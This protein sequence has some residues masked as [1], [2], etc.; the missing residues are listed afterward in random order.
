MQCSVEKEHLFDNEYMGKDYKGGKGRQ[1]PSMCGSSSGS[2]GKS[3]DSYLTGKDYPGDCGHQHSSSGSSSGDY[4]GVMTILQND[5]D[6]ELVRRKPETFQSAIVDGIK[7][8]FGMDSKSKKSSSRTN[9]S[10]D[11]EPFHYVRS[12]TRSL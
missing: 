9:K 1:S 8:F 6:R 4:S 7:Y 3:I 12:V 2:G 11:S 10:R 5:N